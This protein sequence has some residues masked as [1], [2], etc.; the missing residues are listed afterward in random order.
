MS[1]YSLSLIAI[2]LSL[3]AFGVSISLGINESVKKNSKIIYAF[4]FG[5]FQFFF[6]LAGSYAG[7]VFNSIINVP[8]IIGGIVIIIVGA[9]MFKEGNSGSSDFLE[10]KKTYLILGISV[11]IDALVIG[12]TLLNNFTSNIVNFKNC[13][14]IGIVTFI[15]SILAFLFGKSLKKIDVVKA[16][17]DYIGGVILIL[18]G[19]KMIFF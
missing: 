3:D 18:F 9:M 8:K 1:F 15:M 5:F 19:L 12:F 4:S 16:Y 2:A 10:N 11:S 14:Y 7:F 6:A 13:L 17:A